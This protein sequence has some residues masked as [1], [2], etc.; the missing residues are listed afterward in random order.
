MSINDLNTFSHSADKIVASAMEETTAA[1]I[2][3]ITDKTTAYIC[4]KAADLGCELD[5]TVIVS[6]E[7]PYPPQEI[8]LEGNASPYG[9]KILSDI[10]TTELNIPP[11]DQ[12]WVKQK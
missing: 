8:M 4:D 12:I 10:I 2:Q 1:Q 9:K 5:I 7:A 6:S 11:E 3:V